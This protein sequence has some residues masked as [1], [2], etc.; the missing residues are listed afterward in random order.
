MSAEQGPLILWRGLAAGLQVNI[1]FNAVSIGMYVPIRNL[2]TGSLE[3]NQ[4]PSTLQMLAAATISS[5]ASWTIANP[6]QV[7]KIRMQT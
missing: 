7:A 1:L 5:T 2:I 3:P 6:A 4:N